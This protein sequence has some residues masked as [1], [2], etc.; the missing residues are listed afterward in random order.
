MWSP[1]ATILLANLTKAVRFSSKKTDI[2]EALRKIKA[3]YAYN[4]THDDTPIKAIMVILA[5]ADEQRDRM[6]ASATTGMIDHGKH[7]HGQ[8]P[9]DV[10]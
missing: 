9:G 3:V 8:A 6:T 4:H 5:A 10:G 1:L 2:R 7:G